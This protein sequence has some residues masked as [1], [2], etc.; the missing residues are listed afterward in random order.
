MLEVGRFPPGDG[1]ARP[2]AGDFILVSGTSW[3][4]RAITVYQR[5]RARG[6]GRRYVHWNHVALVVGRNGVIVEAGTGGVVLEHIEKY[7]DADYHYV[8]IGAAPTARRLATRFALSRVGSRY[9][10]RAAAGLLLAALTRGR[11]RLQDE[12]REMCGSLVARA[13][14]C[15]GESF[16]LLPAE[17][18]P[19]D[20][21]THYR[22]PDPRGRDL[23]FPP[24]GY[25]DRW[26]S[27]S[28]TE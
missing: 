1:I 5:L 6:D 17:M 26:A 2:Q 19:A 4:A 28:E 8:A 24:R 25:R 18:L 16:E 12:G 10:S 14:A 9:G 11:V 20:L 21:A 7:R 3:R 27:A 23:A 13:L 15:A 22:V